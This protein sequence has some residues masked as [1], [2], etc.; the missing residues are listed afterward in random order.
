MFQPNE[1]QF[2]TAIAIAV[3]GLLVNIVSALLLGHGTGTTMITFMT[4][5][6]TI[7]DTATDIAAAITIYDRPMYMSLPMH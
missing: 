7:M 4:T 6:T 2:G 5:I 3:V 1:V